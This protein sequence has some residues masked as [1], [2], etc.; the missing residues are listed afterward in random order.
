MNNMMRV[1]RKLNESVEIRKDEDTPKCD[2]KINESTGGYDPGNL[3]VGQRVT[4]QVKDAKGQIFNRE[5]TVGYVLA[6]GQIL[7]KDEKDGN[8]YF[9]QYY[10]EDEMGDFIIYSYT[11]DK[12]GITYT[13]KI[14][15]NVGSNNLSNYSSDDDSAL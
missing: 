1:I 8:S 7:I 9:L 6:G 13:L 11:D 3:L 4:V 10:G 5:F 14:H 2:S 15:K 12:T